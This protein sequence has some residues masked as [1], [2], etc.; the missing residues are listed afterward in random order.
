PIPAETLR[1]QEHENR[2]RVAFRVP[3]PGSAVTAE[4]VYRDHTLGQLALPFLS[5]EEFL[6]N[7]RLQMPTLFVRL[8][9]ESVACQTFVSS[10]CRGLLA[11]AV[12]VS[13]T[14]LV[15]LLALDLQV[16]FPCGGGGRACRVRGFRRP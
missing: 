11:S 8:G 15:P 16:E 12:L 2:Y 1:R 14:S 3:P 5:R 4:L 10:Q 6:Q 13:P 7:L 9:T